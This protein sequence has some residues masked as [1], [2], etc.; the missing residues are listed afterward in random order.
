MKKTRSYEEIIAEINL[1]LSELAEA[2][3]KSG[4]VEL[5]R[6]MTSTTGKENYFGPGGGIR[7]LFKEG[8][9]KKPKTASDIIARLHQEGYRYPQKTIAVY[10]LRFVRERVLSRL[11]AK[12]R[13]G[14]E[15]W[16]YTERK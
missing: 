12:N 13:K 10:L 7:L 14:K 4:R 2:S 3:H 9:F 8:F 5:K 11:P 1:L 16:E 15:V 6:S